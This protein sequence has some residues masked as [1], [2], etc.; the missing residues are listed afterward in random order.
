M[1][2]LVCVFELEEVG[3]LCGFLLSSMVVVV[4]CLTNESGVLV[5]K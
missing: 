3:I 1:S 2:L 5:V 4:I